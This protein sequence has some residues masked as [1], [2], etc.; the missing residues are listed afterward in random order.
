M[1]LSDLELQTC[2]RRLR[3]YKVFDGNGLYAEIPPTGNIR[4]RAKYSFGGKEKRL[5]LGLY[6]EVTI[7]QARARC[8]ELKAQVKNGVDPSASRRML[9][10]ELEISKGLAAPRVADP[11]A[12]IAELKQDIVNLLARIHKATCPEPEEAIT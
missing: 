11:Y 3:A 10:F 9:K 1:K 5:S 2:P 7:E 12:L 6:P 4:W 8:E